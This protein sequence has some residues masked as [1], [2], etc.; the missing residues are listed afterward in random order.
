[1][2]VLKKKEH[3]HATIYAHVRLLSGLDTLCTVHVGSIDC[4][5]SCL[6]KIHV[7]HYCN[8]QATPH[9]MLVCQE[10]FEQK[11]CRL[12]VHT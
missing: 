10:D 12:Y 4:L 8:E 9:G 2:C 5:Y 11:L 7:C 1:M 6:C 3:V